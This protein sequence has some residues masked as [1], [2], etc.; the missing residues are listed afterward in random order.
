MKNFLF[1]LTG[2]RPMK[3]GEY[4]MRDRVSGENIYYY[5]DKLGREW[6]ASGSW[7]LFRVAVPVPR[8]VREALIPRRPQ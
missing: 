4:V 3:R 1:W 2:G 6:L 7:A 8:K 5:D